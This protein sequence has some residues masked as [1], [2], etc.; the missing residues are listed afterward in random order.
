MSNSIDHGYTVVRDAEAFVQRL[1]GDKLLKAQERLAFGLVRRNS[2]LPWIEPQSGIGPRHFPASLQPLMVIARTKTREEILQIVTAQPEGTVAHAYRK[3][4]ELSPGEALQLAKQIV[5]GLVRHQESVSE[6]LGGP[7]DPTPGLAPQKTVPDKIAPSARRLDKQDPPN[8][9][10]G[11]FTVCAADVTPK[12]VDAIWADDKGGIRLARGEHTVFAGEPGLGKSQ[13]VIG[14]AA[15]V[16][17][18]GHWPCGEGRAPLGGVIIL[19][20]EDSVEHT[21]VPRLIAAGA[22]LTRIHFVEA[23]AT[24]DGNGRRMFNFQ[25][26]FAKLEK[27]VKATQHVVLVIIDPVT[28]YLGKIDSHKNAEVRGVLVPIGELAR[29]CNI[30]IASV[31]HFTKGGG[32]ASTK[33]LDRIIGSIAFIAAPRIGLTVVDYSFTSKTTSAGAQSDWHSDWNSA[34]WHPMQ[35]AAYQGLV[36]PGRP[37]PLK[38]LRTKSSALRATRR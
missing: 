3:G 24:Q 16:S 23:V 34:S 2:L 12:R 4:I 20:A 8:I 25:S 5:L 10:Y 7:S 31:T 37:L 21:L 13:V 27:L 15:A 9:K 30:A 14:M 18:S 6:K 17:T 26:D 19:A 11:L 32:S 1:T 38:K 22:D 35:R 36:L 29:E 33:A 28:A